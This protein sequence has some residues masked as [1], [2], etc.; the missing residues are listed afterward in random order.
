MPK[1]KSEISNSYA[2][3]L[4]FCSVAP[5]YFARRWFIDAFRP[6]TGLTTARLRITILAFVFNHLGRVHPSDQNNAAFF[7]FFVVHGTSGP[8]GSSWRIQYSKISSVAVF[9][10][11]KL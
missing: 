2:H 5:V 3:Q 11:L 1:C 6:E 7:I 8:R 4:A 9:P 10:T